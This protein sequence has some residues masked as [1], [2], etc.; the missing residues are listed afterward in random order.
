MR[1]CMINQPRPSL[2]TR[3]TIKTLKFSSIEQVSLVFSEPASCLHFLFKIVYLKLSRKY[4]A[5][6][7]ESVIQYSALNIFLFTKYLCFCHENRGK[8]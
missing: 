6:S 7:P 3:L 4:L 5:L 2:G 8:R 1:G